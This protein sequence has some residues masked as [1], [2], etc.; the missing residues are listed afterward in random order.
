MP[1]SRSFDREIQNAMPAD[2]HRLR[3]ELPRSGTRKNAARPV[4]RRLARWKQ[5]LQRSIALYK[6][7]RAG[8]PTIRF[9]DDLPVSQ[10]RD[11]IAAAIRD[12]Q[13]VIVCGETGSGKST[14]LPKICLELGRGH[15]RPDRP[16]P[17]AAD[18]RPVASPRGSPRSWARRWAA[19][20]ASRSASPTPPARK[21]YIKLMTDGILLAEIQGDPL[22]DQYDTIILDEAH[23][24]SLNID[25]LI[26][27]LKRLLPK[28]RDLKLIITSA[29]IDAARFAEHFASPRRPGA[30]GRGLRPHVPGGDPLA[31]ASSR[32]RKA[33]SPTWTTPCCDA[34][35]ELASH[36]P[37]RH[38]H[39]HAHRARH[40]RDGQGA[41]R[42][43]AARRLRRPDD[44]NP[45][46]LRPAFDPGAAAGLPAARRTGGS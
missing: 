2:R 34:V 29:T 20:W 43:H 16:H 44:G 36:R 26:G 11:E 10:R 8:V 22:L 31:A 30:G 23:E 25:F 46:A 18:R 45:A 13:V 19:T 28:R 38:P 5:E 42:P 17:A 39:L 33:T 40:P 14:Q 41:P 6:G 35:D 37:G 27:Y 3:K 4:D 15:R 1:S 32:T 24:R 7:R 9:D 21:T 12:H